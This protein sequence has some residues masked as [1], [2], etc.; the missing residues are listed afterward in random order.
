MSRVD[1]SLGISRLR[2]F[3]AALGP[4]SPLATLRTYTP[5]SRLLLAEAERAAELALH[6]VRAVFWL[7]MTVLVSPEIGLVTPTFAPLILLGILMGAGLWGLIWQVLRRP[8]PPIWLRYGLIVLDG[9]LAVRS[10]L[11]FDAP[12]RERFVSVFGM[13]QISVPDLVV[14]TPTLLVFLALSGALR[15]DVRAAVLSTVV[16]LAA[17]AFFA[18]SVALP[19][20]QALPVAA[21]IGFA[22][23]VG[24]NGARI[25]RYMVLKAREQAVLEHYLPQ[26]LTREL[27]RSGTVDRAGRQ[28]E[29]TLLMADI[30]GYS[31]LTE[32]LEPAAAV[33]LL[34]EYFAVVAAPL[35]ADGAVLD[36][37]IGDGILAFFEGA[38]HATRG[39]RAARGMLAEL[40]AF[41]AQRPGHAPLRI[42]IAVHTGEVL[43][44]TIG[45]PIR[46]EYTL[47]G[48][49]VN[50][51]ARLEECNKRFDSVLIAS[52]T[53]LARSSVP[54]G[55]L[56]G[57]ELVDLRGRGAPIA[58]HYLPAGRNDRTAESSYGKVQPA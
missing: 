12:F 35:A 46:R 40:D 8:V 44:G 39:L 41:N 6:G 33:A 18:V 58:I 22:G 5:A 47:I 34:N 4:Y 50:V 56:C 7:L 10:A 43:V 14:L 25:L 13:P 48:D 1:E 53:T 31:R 23:I 32:R 37:Y 2:R 30:R 42:G 21:V 19:A 52:A 36:K 45:A 29:L 26:G 11:L 17:Y 24:A 16:A 51:T 57:P 27:A 15:I 49:A 20:R 9:W 38:D 3:F 28:E 55:D 54:S